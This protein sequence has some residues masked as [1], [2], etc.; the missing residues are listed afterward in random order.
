MFGRSKHMHIADADDAELDAFETF[1]IDVLETFCGALIE[2]GWFFAGG[3]SRRNAPICE[4]CAVAAGWEW[5][6]ASQ[7]WYAA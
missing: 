7:D 5:D 1:Q 3:G 2:R 4:P 6:E